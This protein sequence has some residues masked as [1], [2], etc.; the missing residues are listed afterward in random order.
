MTVAQIKLVNEVVGILRIELE[1]VHD[2][3]AHGVP[4]L[5]AV[6]QVLQAIQQ[7][8]GGVRLDKHGVRARDTAVSCL[9][10]LSVWGGFVH[11][12]WMRAA[13]CCIFTITQLVDAD[14][15]HPV[16]NSEW[17]PP[18]DAAQ[19]VCCLAHGCV[20]DA[21][22]ALHGQGAPLPD[23]ARDTRVRQPHPSSRKHPPRCPAY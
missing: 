11:N 15:E 17:A 18:P 13:S 8:H 2:D 19:M 22:A 16:M 3:D 10:A 23:P 4:V 5:L 21:G 20:H 7:I 12:W 1:K 9:E 14:E 6:G